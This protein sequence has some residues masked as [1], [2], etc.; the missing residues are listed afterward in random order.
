[1]KTQRLSYYYFHFFR[2]LSAGM[3]VLVT[4]MMLLHHETTLPLP[5]LRGWWP[6]VPIALQTQTPNH[7]PKKWDHL[8]INY[9]L[10]LP[11]YKISKTQGSQRY[12]WWRIQA[13]EERS[14]TGTKRMQKHTIDIEDSYN[15]PR[16]FADLQ[17]RAFVNV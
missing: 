10:M 3:F 16:I 9:N 11:S 13:R 15:D 5:F 8:V 7:L 2:Y 17:R 6:F 14:Y 4:P 12:L 1:M